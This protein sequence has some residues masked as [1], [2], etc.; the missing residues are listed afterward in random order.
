LLLLPC[1]PASPLHRLDGLPFATRAW[2]PR[3]VLPSY[4]LSPRPP[5]IAGIPDVWL[6]LAAPIIA[7]W[8]VS[9][10]F[11]IIDELDLFPQYRLHTPAEI[12]KRNRV[13][14]W[15]VFRDVVLQQI[16]QTLAGLAL[17][18]LD[19]PEMSG[20]EEYEVAAWAL[21]LRKLQAW[22]PLLL[23]LAGLDSAT[24][25]ARLR[26]AYPTLAAIVGGGAY[27]QPGFAAWEL[28]VAGFVYWLAV[29][30][31]QL[32]AASIAIDTWEYFLHRAMHL[33]RFLYN[34]L[35][36]RHHRLY[37]PY[38]FGALYNHPLE[39]F[40]LDTVGGG[41]GYMLTGMTVRQGMLFFTLSTIKTVDDHCGYALPWDPLQHLTSN[42]AA[43]HDIHHQS[44]GIKTNFSQPFFTFW[45]HFLG[46]VW[47]GGDVKLRYERDRAAAQRKV[48]ADQ[49][50]ALH[51]SLARSA[52]A[53]PGR[54][55]VAADELRDERDLK[56]ATRRSTR[57]KSGFDAKA[58]T[59]RVAASLSQDAIHR[60][61]HVL[62]LLPNIDPLEYSN[63]VLSSIKALPD[64]LKRKSRLSSLLSKASRKS[65]LCQL[66]SLLAFDLVDALFRLLT[67]ECSGRMTGLAA[68]GPLLPPN[69]QARVQRIQECY[70]RCIHADPYLNAIQPGA[71]SKSLAQTSKCPACC[72]ARLATHPD[73]L[74]DL[75]V[76]TRSRHDQ[77][78]ATITR[79]LDSFLSCYTKHLDSQTFMSL[80]A[81]V[82]E[83][84][85]AL[86]ACRQ[87]LH[88]IRIECG[89]KEGEPLPQLSGPP[90]RANTPSL[91]STSTPIEPEA[92]PYDSVLSIV[93]LY[94]SLR[95]SHPLSPDHAALSTNPDPFPPSPSPLCNVYSTVDSGYNTASLQNKHPTVS[96]SQSSG[97][98][99]PT[100]DNS[101]DETLQNRSKGEWEGK[102]ESQPRPG[103]GSQSGLY[104]KTVNP[105]TGR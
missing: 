14:R 83:E 69:Q 95:S 54:H 12:A 77:R 38:A 66:H 41:I 25:S 47:K 34:W 59:D 60:L 46:T 62:R 5:L 48:D 89:A 58:L 87:M 97:S 4:T 35:H 13:T 56:Q 57:R 72:L 70:Q 8:A 23:R 53:D 92:E 63:W 64:P 36:S 29:P 2:A 11:H 42:N 49:A 1:G 101:S 81:A 28:H 104:A 93:N 71:R 84:T 31:M 67:L 18:A 55:P 96:S 98:S 9:L 90:E 100:S 43:Y 50:A 20:K 99:K 73:F 19:P 17:A 78:P 45:D 26:P 88:R 16:I 85:A 65:H 79:Y 74:L 51:A 27:G 52:A 15:E 105:E 40:L 82:E 33:N 80:F 24:L 30:A 22:L 6:Q 86:R 44:W 61:T 7:Y 75:L 21:A 91:L 32:T 39:G 76:V 103:C 102:G 3:R 94:D 68:N 10:F 37:V